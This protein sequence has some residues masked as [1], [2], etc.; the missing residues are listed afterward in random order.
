MINPLYRIAFQ[1]AVGCR[2]LIVL[3][4]FATPTLAR[5]GD[6]DLAFNP[7]TA[8]TSSLR[9]ATIDSQDR[10]I[11]AGDF[12]NFN[13]SH[14]ARIARLRV[15]GSLDPE[16][17]AGSGANDTITAIEILAD[18]RILVGGK[19]TQFNGVT[20]RGL[21]MLQPNGN[22]DQSFLSRFGSEGFSVGVTCIE[23]LP[24]SKFIVG[25]Y[26]DRYAGQ[27]V[28]RYVFLT[29]NGD[30]DP[31]VARNGGAN[32][33]VFDVDLQSD[34]SILICGFF[35]TVDGFASSCVARLYAGGTVDQN[36]STG[37]Q[38]GTVAYTVEGQPD[39]KVIVGGSFSTFFGLGKRYLGR[40]TSSGGLDTGFKAN[41]GPDLNVYGLTVDPQ[42][43][44]LVAGQFSKFAGSPM[45]GIGR[46]LP[47]GSR[48]P[49]FE[50]TPT[51]SVS[52]VQEFPLDSHGRIVAYGWSDFFINSPIGT[53]RRLI[54]GNWTPRQAWLFRHYGS[55]LP[56]GMAA[57]DAEPGGD[58]LSN[59]EKYA[60]GSQGDPRTPTKLWGDDGLLRGFWADSSSSGFRFRTD[61]ERTDVTAIAEWSIA[62]SGWTRDGIVLTEESRDGSVV[63]WK[64]TVHGYKQAAFFRI[65]IDLTD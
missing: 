53:V 13:G 33:H 12:T 16:F 58:G 1:I 42:G 56:A 38:L 51:V 3:S 40:L 28:G 7:G 63:T 61:L 5:P 4:T 15:D 10:V 24:N 31:S 8:T 54:G 43:R 18:G 11:V 2:C 25:G 46:L 30:L 14:A 23:A 27:P 52:F 57:W 65:A 48:D 44:I 34:G 21:V 20:T 47:D 22:I 64:A 50:F 39:G 59:L 62:L 60:L 37:T 55:D 41:I 32:S 6:L 35:T 19:F 26:F 36:F 29:T 9:A 17:S 49:D 45:K